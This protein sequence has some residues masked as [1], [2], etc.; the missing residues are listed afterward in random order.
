MYRRV[1][2]TSTPAEFRIKNA[3]EGTS[4]RN[5]FYAGASKGRLKN[6]DGPL[7]G[8]LEKIICN[9]IYIDGKR[10][11]DMANEGQSGGIKR[12]GRYT[13]AICVTPDVKKRHII[14]LRAKNMD[15]IKS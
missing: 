15:R 7:H 11:G 8:R 4:N 13:H 12:Q 10:R 1:C 6:S 14:S 9:V 2:I 3:A 5:G